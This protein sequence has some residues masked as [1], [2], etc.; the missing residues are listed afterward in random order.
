MLLITQANLADFVDMVVM[1]QGAFSGFPWYESLTTE[2]VETHILNHM[3]KPGFGA[4]V[5]KLDGISVGASWWNLPSLNDIS[6]E[7]GQ[8]LATFAEKRK[9]KNL[10]WEREILIRPEYQGR[11]Y[12]VELRTSFLNGLPKGS[13]L[14]LTRMRDDNTP[15]LKTAQKL[16]FVSTGVKA[17]SSGSDIYHQYYFLEM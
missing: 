17:K 8:E 15:T 9:F 6:V 4:L 11:G 7:R 1:Y 10:V 14:V 16:G 13:T 5:V 3:R 12:S 2:E